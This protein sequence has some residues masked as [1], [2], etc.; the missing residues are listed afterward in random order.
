LELGCLDQCPQPLRLIVRRA[1]GTR[2]YGEAGP[3]PFG[4]LPVG[5]TPHRAAPREAQG[6]ETA[7]GGAALR[8]RKAET[9]ATAA[10]TAAQLVRRGGKRFAMPGAVITAR[11]DTCTVR[12]HRTDAFA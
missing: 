8:N 6:Y 9:A 10:A 12:G 2:G 1:R 4:K 11:R 3:G 7:S 5:A